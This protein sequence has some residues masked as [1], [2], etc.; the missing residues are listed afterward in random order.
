MCVWGVG[1]CKNE[2]L[3]YLVEKKKKEKIENGV[4]INL[5]LCPYYIKIFNNL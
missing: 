1:K 5:F 2:K 3:F 4:C